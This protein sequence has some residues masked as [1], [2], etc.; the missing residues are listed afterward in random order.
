[1]VKMLT[2]SLVLL[3]VII[4]AAAAFYFWNSSRNVVTP[5]A[6]P[7]TTV[8]VADT[9]DSDTVSAIDT[10]EAPKDDLANDP[11]AEY[12]GNSDI[13][14]KPYKVV[15]IEEVTIEEDVDLED[16]SREHLGKHREDY[17]KVVNGGKKKFKA[18]EKVKV[19]VLEKR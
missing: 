11:Y 14:H 1:M 12:N 7:E 18:G 13:K 16:F 15:G 2:A 19:P 17:V 3:V 6:E 9:I 5:V 10:V 8:Q 4:A